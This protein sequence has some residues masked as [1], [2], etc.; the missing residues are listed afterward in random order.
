MWCSGSTIGSKSLSDLF[1]YFFDLYSVCC[2]GWKLIDDQI[3]KYIRYVHC[4]F[5]SS[6]TIAR[7]A[8]LADLI[9]DLG[10][11]FIEIFLP[12]TIWCKM[13]W[14]HCWNHHHNILLV[15][16]C[17]PSLCVTSLRTIY[18]IIEMSRLW[19]TKSCE[20]KHIKNTFNSKYP[21]SPFY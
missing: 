6:I 15:T 13:I 18:S 16:A 10:V 2:R 21:C 9:Y 3:T 7:W 19:Q 1:F 17:V 5:S 20:L 8:V 14:S 4:D 12:S 11:V